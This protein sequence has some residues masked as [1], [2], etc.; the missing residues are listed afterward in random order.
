MRYPTLAVITL[1]GGLALATTA[2]SQRGAPP[3]RAPMPA[4]PSVNATPPSTAVNPGVTQRD[5]A[6]VNRE[7]P[8]H[9]SPTGIANANENAGL[10][11]TTAADLSGLSTGL[12]VKDSTGATIG[13]VSKIEKSR[14]GTVKNVLVNAAGGTRTIRLAPGSLSVSGEVVTTTATPK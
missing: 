3:V 5:E 7:G 9:A 14:D 1:A 10:S 13:T 4:T 2:A 6:R 12:T 8:E 11:S